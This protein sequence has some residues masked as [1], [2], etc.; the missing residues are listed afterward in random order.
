MAEG[1]ILRKIKNRSALRRMT[2]L[3]TLA[4]AAL[5]ASGGA[6]EAAII[7]HPTH[8]ASVLPL[9]GGNQLQISVSARFTYSSRTTG[10][11]TFYGPKGRIERELVV[12]RRTHSFRIAASGVPFRTEG[13]IIAFAR[14]GQ[15]F[16]Q[17]GAGSGRGS[18]GQ[19]RRGIRGDFS[20]VRYFYAPPA[21]SVTV[22]SSFAYHFAR[23]GS[24]GSVRQTVAKSSGASFGGFRRDRTTLYVRAFLAGYGDQYALFRFSVGSQTDYGWLELDLG[25]SGYPADPVVSTV[26]YAYDTSGKPIPAGYT[27]IPEP[28]EIPLALSALSLGAIGLREWRKR[29]GSPVRQ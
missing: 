29:S 21:L 4:S 26:A 10:A 16:G 5:A 7:Y 27:G 23:S 15:T 9:P 11:G 6:G 3:S 18:L 19:Y 25:P 1:L 12:G 17:I 22:P 24:T 14:K 2:S 28:R 13:G 8:G 20:F